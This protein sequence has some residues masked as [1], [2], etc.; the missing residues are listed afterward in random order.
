MLHVLVAKSFRSHPHRSEEKEAPT[1]GVEFR[2]QVFSVR[3]K[4]RI[5]LEDVY[6]VISQGR[7]DGV[8]Q[9]NTGIFQVV[10]SDPKCGAFL[11]PQNPHS[12][13]VVVVCFGG[14]GEAGELYEVALDPS[15]ALQNQSTFYTAKLSGWKSV[16]DRFPIHLKLI[17]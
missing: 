10:F 11:E 16:Q 13:R 9:V 15:L 17:H 8:R 6:P 2:A 3:E 1:K 5:G 4:S 14:A 7:S 12:Q